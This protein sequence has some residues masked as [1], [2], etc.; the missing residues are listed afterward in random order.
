MAIFYS[1]FTK[2]TNMFISSSGWTRKWSTA[3]SSL[4]S[5]YS[6][7][8]TKKLKLFWII[9]LTDG[10]FSTRVYT[11]QSIYDWSSGFDTTK[12]KSGFFWRLVLVTNLKNNWRGSSSNVARRRS[13]LAID[14]PQSKSY[15]VGDPPPP[16]V[17]PMYKAFLNPV[18][19]E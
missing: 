9:A 13:S 11:T 8:T 6:W 17:P 2:Q 5:N 16:S 15:C 14:I 4:S 19:R 3:L 7:E 10:E 1:C 18:Q 12:R